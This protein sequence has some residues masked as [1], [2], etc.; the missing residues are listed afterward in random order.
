MLKITLLD[1]FNSSG[2][3]KFDSDKVVEVNNING[4]GRKIKYLSKVK[5]IELLPKFKRSNFTKIKINKSCKTDFV[6]LKGKIAFTQLK[7]PLP[8][9]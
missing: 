3:I 2:V 9:Y 5:N 1:F 6:T 4:S 8:K 7:K